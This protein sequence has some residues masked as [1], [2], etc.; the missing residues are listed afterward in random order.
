MIRQR[1]GLTVALATWMVVVLAPLAQAQGVVQPKI[2]AVHFKLDPPGYSSGSIMTTVY[3]SGFGHFGAPLPYDGNIPNFVL[4]DLSQGWSAGNTGTHLCAN[5]SCGN[6]GWPDKYLIWTNSEV[7][8]VFIGEAAGWTPGDKAE[9]ALSNPESG[10]SASWTGPLLTYVPP[11][12]PA[13]V[14]VNGF[15][16]TGATGPYGTAE[17]QMLA[18]LPAASTVVASEVAICVLHPS[19]A[20]QIRGGSGLLIAWD[21]AP[22][23]AFIHDDT[24]TEERVA[25]ALENYMR[26][27]LSHTR[28]LYLATLHADRVPEQ[29][30]HLQDWWAVR[31]QSM[32]TTNQMMT[33]EVAQTFSTPKPP[34]ISWSNVPGY[35]VVKPSLAIRALASLLYYSK[36][37]AGSLG[38]PS[39]NVTTSTTTV[40]G[41]STLV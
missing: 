7:Q 25:A 27:T 20:Q 34:G 40:P 21:A 31:V 15:S 38:R 2:A 30:S 32:S 14:T 37:I 23:V 24:P 39:A 36:S 17:R 10:L 4:E 35:P 1:R 6:N 13:S 28:T 33:F 12:P 8:V 5:L 9:V 3:G 29:D 18:Q 16:V 26:M 22:T 41:A 11:V 19:S